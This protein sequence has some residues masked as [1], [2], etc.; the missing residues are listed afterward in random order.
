MKNCLELIKPPNKP[1]HVFDSKKRC[2]GPSRT[3]IEHSL[4][5]WKEKLA[6]LRTFVRRG[7][8]AIYKSVKES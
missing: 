7:F 3:H 8:G 6:R 5:M 1:K 4:A 2:S